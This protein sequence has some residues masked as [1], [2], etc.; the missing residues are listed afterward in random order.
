M[1]FSNA[2]K[3]KFSNTYKTKFSNM[4]KFH[5]TEKA[6]S[7]EKITK[8]IKIE[9]IFNNYNYNRIN[10]NIDFILPSST[11]IYTKN[12][13]NNDKNTN[14]GIIKDQ[15]KKEGLLNYIDMALLGLD[16]NG[17]NLSSTNEFLDIYHILINHEYEIYKIY[18]K[19]EIMITQKSLDDKFMDID[20]NNIKKYLYNESDQNV[21]IFIKNILFQIEI[22]G[23][24]PILFYLHDFYNMINIKPIDELLQNYD[25]KIIFIETPLKIKPLNIQ[26]IY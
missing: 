25:I 18:G 7:I 24:N 19:F 4:F 21:K 16:K 22:L 12:D 3:M 2:Y 17:Y 9:N 5:K 13:D 23:N 14:K 11:S 10:D 15:K 1:K 6:N 26:L 20:I 8:D